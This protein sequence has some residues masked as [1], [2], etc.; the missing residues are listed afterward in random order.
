M[1]IVSSDN[2]DDSK[3]FRY[4]T[5]KHHVEIRAPNEEDTRAKLQK[6]ADFVRAYALG[7]EL[8]DALALVRLDH[9]FLESF[10]VTDGE[11]SISI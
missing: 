3:L 4:N 11:S 7:F 6:A 5:V 8:D 9:L 10:D 1:I 2:G